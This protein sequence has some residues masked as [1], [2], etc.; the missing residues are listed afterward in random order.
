MKKLI[1]NIRDHIEA[2]IIL[3][4][5]YLIDELEAQIE[6]QKV[7]IFDDVINRIHNNEPPKDDMET[8][9]YCE[10]IGWIEQY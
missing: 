3:E 2:G 8:C 5:M 1:K 6:Q 9:R 7:D 10:G 4:H